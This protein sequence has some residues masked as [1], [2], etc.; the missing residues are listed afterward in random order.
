VAQQ[1]QFQ[2]DDQIY[3]L[4]TA[5]GKTRRAYG[6]VVDT[7]SHGQIVDIR[8]DEAAPTWSYHVSDVFPANA[9]TSEEAVDHVL[10]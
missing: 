6:R 1:Q 7:W 8:F 4:Y 5:Y 9:D 3:V 2:P 10:C